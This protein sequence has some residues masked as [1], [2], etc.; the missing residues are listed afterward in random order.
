MI[1]LTI[2]LYKED[3]RYGTEPLGSFADEVTEEHQCMLV[4]TLVR[5]RLNN[6]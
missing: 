1:V 2:G 6:E 4:T 5:H 3:D